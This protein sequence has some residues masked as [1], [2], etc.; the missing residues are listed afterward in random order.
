MIYHSTL[1]RGACNWAAKKKQYI[2][3]VPTCHTKS[4]RYLNSPSLPLL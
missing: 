4:K 1:E 3:A 2:D